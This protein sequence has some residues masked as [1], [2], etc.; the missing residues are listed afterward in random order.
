MRAH[1]RR[2]SEPAWPLG[3][4]QAVGRLNRGASG[5]GRRTGSQPSRGCPRGS[6]RGDGRGWRGCRSRPESARRTSA[7]GTQTAG[8]DGLLITGRDDQNPLVLQIFSG[9]LTSTSHFQNNKLLI[10][11]SRMCASPPLP[12]PP[13]ALVILQNSSKVKVDYM[14]H[15]TITRVYESLKKCRLLKR[16]CSLT[17]PHYDLNKNSS[18]D[19]W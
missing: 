9:V 14:F 15:A 8:G 10:S 2:R 13:P 19:W 16:N 3:R 6:G 18:Q 11:H 1:C 4:P 5:V 7:F 12:P 17:R